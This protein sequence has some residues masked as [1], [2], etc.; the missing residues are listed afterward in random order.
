MWTLRVGVLKKKRPS[1]RELLKISVQVLASYKFP[2][3]IFSSFLG[4]WGD[5]LLA[6]LPV[7]A[8]SAPVSESTADDYFV[9]PNSGF[10]RSCMLSVYINFGFLRI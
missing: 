1:I 10:I 6:A 8:D 4:G 2:R 5:D 9:M 3:D 7:I